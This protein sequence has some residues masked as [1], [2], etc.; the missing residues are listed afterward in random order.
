M[1]CPSYPN[2]EIRIWGGSA[3]KK[4]NKFADF[5]TLNA[6]TGGSSSSSSKAYR[7]DLRVASSQ[8]TVERMPGAGL[9]RDATMVPPME[10]WGVP[11][12]PSP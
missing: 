6:N 8:R 11:P 7:I 3:D 12:A 10:R 9:V 2:M 1:E 5:S 4:I